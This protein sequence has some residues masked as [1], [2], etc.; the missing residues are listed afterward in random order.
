MKTGLGCF[1]LGVVAGVLGT[2]LYFRLQSENDADQPEELAEKL[3][4]NIAELEARM[5]SLLGET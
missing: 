1:A 4:E 5:R 2:L 3:G